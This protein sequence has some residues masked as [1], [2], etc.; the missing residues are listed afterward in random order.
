M[1]GKRKKKKKLCSN[2]KHFKELTYGPPGTIVRGHCAV[3]S[4]DP[5]KL[6]AS[7]IPCRNGLFVNKHFEVRVRIFPEAG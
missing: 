6:I 2:C 5:D 7:I 1:E 3:N 4:A